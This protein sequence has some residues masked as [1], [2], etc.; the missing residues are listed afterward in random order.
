MSTWNHPQ[1][2]HQC[3]AVGPGGRGRDPPASQ[4]AFESHRAECLIV[5][6]RSEAPLLIMRST[7]RLVSLILWSLARA[8]VLVPQARGVSG[9]TAWLPTQVCLLLEP[10]TACILHAGI[11][12][13]V[14]TETGTRRVYLFEEGRGG[15]STLTHPLSKP[16]RRGWMAPTLGAC[17]A[18][19][20]GM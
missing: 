13:T 7:A 18:C 5:G 20:I 9:E 19:T 8:I 6:L 11:C 1:R 4:P 17:A 14:G 15:R 12:G 10:T 16:A 3:V 2:P